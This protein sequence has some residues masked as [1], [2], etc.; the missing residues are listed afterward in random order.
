[1]SNENNGVRCG[2]CDL[3]PQ[4]FPPGPPDD[5]SASGGVSQVSHPGE[6]VWVREERGPGPR[7]LDADRGRVQPPGVSRLSSPT[8]DPKQPAEILSTGQKRKRVEFFY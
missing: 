3:G 7:D 4:E 1:M 5:C 6:R 8:W 2:R